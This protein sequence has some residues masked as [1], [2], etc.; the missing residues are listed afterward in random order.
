MVPR[1][2]HRLWLT[3]ILLTTLSMVLSSL[4]PFVAA[5]PLSGDETGTSLEQS[6]DSNATLEGSG[7]GASR[8]EQAGG[9]DLSEDQSG[10]PQ[11][12]TEPS[13]GGTGTGQEDCTAEAREKIGDEQGD[14][15]CDPRSGAATEQGAGDS[16]SANNGTPP[17]EE[18]P[19]DE[20]QKE[21]CPPTEPPKG[22]EPCDPGQKL[23]CP[24]VGEQPPKGDSGPGKTGETDGGVGTFSNLRQGNPGERCDF[25]NKD[26]NDITCIRITVWKIW[27]Y[28]AVQRPTGATITLTI[29]GQDYTVTCTH[30]T[31]QA[32]CGTIDVVMDANTSIQVTES[33]TGN[34]SPPFEWV[35]DAGPGSYTFLGANVQIGT[36]P[37][38][39]NQ[40]IPSW[41][42]TGTVWDCI[43]PEQFC[44]VKV[45]NRPLRRLLYLSKYWNPV[46]NPIPSIDL[47]VT[48]Y[49]NQNNIVSGPTPYTCPP[50]N[51]ALC[52]GPIVLPD[53]ATTYEVQEPNP[54]SGYNVSGTGQFNWPNNLFGPHSHS[55]YNW[56]RQTSQPLIHIRITKEWRNPWGLDPR[57]PGA[58][59]TI[60]ID[61]GRT[62]N[63]TCPMGGTSGPFSPTSVYCYELQLPIDAIADGQQVTVSEVAPAG[64]TP[65]QPSG[66]TITWTW[67]SANPSAM[68][69]LGL[70][71][72]G[73]ATDRIRC[74]VRF[75]NQQ[76]VPRAYRL[77]LHVHK[78]WKAYDYWPLQPA[79]I[80]A[81][82]GSQTGSIVCP[83]AWP[84][85]YN[86]NEWIY[87]G[88]ITFDNVTYLDT[89]QSLVERPP[90]PDWGYR[91][92]GDNVIRGCG[93]VTVPTEIRCDH[94]VENTP[95][96]NVLRVRKRWSDPQGSGIAPVPATITVTLLNGAVLQVTCTPP[97]GYDTN[98]NNPNGAP[99][100]LCGSRR[101]NVAMNDL[102]DVQEQI[103]GDWG[104]V[105]G[106]G[107][108]QVG[109]ADPALQCQ[110][111]QG[112]VECDLTV[113]N[114]APLAFRIY[115]RKWWR[116]ADGQATSG[117]AT[118]IQLVVDGQTIDVP[119][120]A[121]STPVTCATLEYPD[122]PPTL[123][124]VNE[125]A[126]PPGWL[127]QSGTGSFNQVCNPYCT[128]NVVNAQEYRVYVSK[129]WTLAADGSL[130]PATM[131]PGATLVVTINGQQQTISCPA[132]QPTGLCEELVL[133]GRP[134]QLVVT[135]PNPPTGWQPSGTGDYTDTCRQYA[136]TCPIQIVNEYRAPH[137]VVQKRWMVRQWL[138]APPPYPA[139][140]LAV[141][142]DGVTEDVNCPAQSTYGPVTC[143]VL[144]LTGAPGSISVSER[145][146]PAPWQYVGYTVSGDCAQ[147]CVLRVTNSRNPVMRIEKAWYRGWVW[148]SSSDVPAVTLAVTLTYQ[149]GQTAQ[150]TLTC[151]AGANPSPCGQIVLDDRFASADFQEPGLGE[152][153][154]FE[155]PPW[156]QLPSCNSNDCT[157]RVT[158]RDMRRQIRVEK[159]WLRGGGW[160]PIPA[161]EVP[162][163]QLTV[164]VTLQGG[165][166][167]TQTLTCPAGQ[168][169]SNCGTVAV[170][171]QVQS[172]TVSEPNLP[173][174]WVLEGVSGTWSCA[175]DDCTVTVTNRYMRRQIRVE[176][177]WLRGGGWNPIPAAEV[178]Q[179]QL[180]V[181][182]TLQGGGEVTQTLTCPAGQ[183]PSNCGTVAVTGQVQSVTVSEPNLPEGWVLEGV[184][185]TS[186]CAYYD[187]IVSV[188]NRDSRYR[189]FVSKEWRG[190]DGSLLDPGQTPGATIE[191]TIDGTTYTFDCPAGVA[192]PVD[193]GQVGLPSRPS[194]IEVTEPAVGDEWVPVVPDVSE[195]LRRWA[196]ECR[197]QVTNWRN[198]PFTI[199]VTKYWVDPMW[200]VVSADEISSTAI[201]VWV[202]GQ[203]YDLTCT[204]GSNPDTCG[205]IDLDRWPRR[206]V[207]DE[208]SVPS[209]WEVVY[210]TGDQSQCTRWGNSCDIYV[211]NQMTATMIGVVK[212]WYDTNWYSVPGPETYVQVTVD[213]VTFVLTCPATDSGYA[214]CGSLTIPGRPTSIR[215]DEPWLPEGWTLVWGAGDYDQCAGRGCFIWLYNQAGGNG[216][217]DRPRRQYA[218]EVRKEW[219]S[220]GQHASQHPPTRLEVT[221]EQGGGRVT[222]ALTC[223]ANEP[224]PQSCGVVMLTGRPDR[225][226]VREPVVLDG[227]RAVAETVTVD[228]CP[229]AG[230]CVVTFTNE[231]RQPSPT[232]S[233]RLAVVKRWLDERGQDTSAHPA[234]TLE[235]SV[236]G[237]SGSRTFTVQCAAGGPSPQVCHTEELSEAP[238]RV[239]VREVRVPAGWVAIVGS[240]SRECDGSETCQVGLVN[241]VSSGTGSGG[242]GGGGTSSGGEGEPV[243]E[244]PP[245]SGT[246]DSASQGGGS[247]GSNQGVGQ[248]PPA[249]QSAERGEAA[250][251]QGQEWSIEDE[252]L[253]EALRER[254][255]IES[256]E[257][258]LIQLLPRTG[259]GGGTNWSASAV[260]LLGI[261]L[262]LTGLALALSSRTGRP[263]AVAAGSERGAS[264]GAGRSGSDRAR[265]PLGGRHW[266]ARGRG[267]PPG[268]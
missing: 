190:D 124:A 81:T 216:G 267:R 233:Y 160:N 140:T 202:D 118:T 20:N 198:G 3:V 266:S 268:R 33:I 6:R 94:Y 145:D 12:G 136:Q 235:V 37:I 117:P 105:S 84:G 260:A 53:N 218:V 57:D 207:V 176:K 17:K 26:P 22:G 134:W 241:V 262:L 211:V 240:A 104:P 155:P 227:W 114:Q 93:W 215:V 34:P 82:V 119:C 91:H 126:L 55:V 180:T 175:Y 90:L 56:Q 128:V 184:S 61:D 153:W 208:P 139:V 265:P 170:I 121:G 141:T 30:N 52:A 152:G 2:L 31:N 232:G 79:T 123:Q 102:L 225:V 163:Q 159:W 234:T 13:G 5:D 25:D 50:T 197:I 19:C 231:R 253:S 58:P 249:Q 60:A 98:P 221:I 196:E 75:V 14:V 252:R 83:R 210:G 230:P 226:I 1:S 44:G 69:R 24:P 66:G 43:N 106:V 125:P 28:N 142:I 100:V 201:T 206:I 130:A 108:I 151:Q 213:G 228:N 133:P 220:D 9:R 195:C 246:P 46:P 150:Y 107:V 135:E 187:C 209:G 165:G 245:P 192:N 189:V 251:Y 177:W 193:C 77:Q 161:A 188:T 110:Q 243:L 111:V 255:K 122:A 181:T 68:D 95:Y 32:I 97:A 217:G 29:A 186:W 92:W 54:P 74:E 239:T 148:M 115:V 18:K 65:L 224:S 212:A 103:S 39:G 214:N 168:N 162:Q 229:E 48:L 71:C 73:S 59:V 78:Y 219:L 156:W 23:D 62:W 172:V 27:Y 147:G 109:G 164:T 89:L 157:V 7:P 112:R 169:P 250:T 185:D 257:L 38:A 223:A 41:A 76:D 67:N 131:V 70:S 8:E 242:G 144:F 85:S 204:G 113:T 146:L 149:N 120:P 40:P 191:V 171:G 96:V 166:E 72:S 138:D 35:T 248:Q 45:Y 87:C 259:R 244:E 200:N 222:L 4:S 199:R 258:Q 127:V 86:L 247:G 167:V 254:K 182:V 63:A 49:D 173:E 183:N 64:W 21:G 116:T 11:S 129:R 137:V 203:S 16:D 178:P 10:V 42:G 36:D 154:T 158:N 47:Q 264:G 263:R 99:P 238:V 237:P 261:A 179:Q 143:G 80:E 101:V 205:Q 174:G 88:V 236:E 256:E 15:A 194:S 51:G 132:N